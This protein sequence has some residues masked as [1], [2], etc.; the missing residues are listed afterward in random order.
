MTHSNI[1]ASLCVRKPVIVRTTFK[2]RIWEA[3]WTLHHRKFHRYVIGDVF[4]VLV[5]YRRTLAGG[6]TTQ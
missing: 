5:I 3:T 1:S 6:Y 2:G 4:K